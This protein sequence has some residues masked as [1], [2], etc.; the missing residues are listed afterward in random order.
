VSERYCRDCRHFSGI[1][2]AE[3]RHPESPRDMVYGWTS[4][5]SLMRAKNTLCGA[6]ARL[7]QV[8]EEQPKK[9]GFLRK[10][11]GA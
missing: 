4:K 3:C 8:K 10:V 7:F 2:L 11:F 1:H 6:D 9:V 5:A